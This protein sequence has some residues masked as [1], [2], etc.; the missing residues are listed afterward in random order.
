MPLNK[1]YVGVCNGSNGL[2]TFCLIGTA[3]FA[4]SAHLKHT[5]FASWHRLSATQSLISRLRRFTDARFWLAGPS[6]L[7]GG[8]LAQVQLFVELFSTEV[9]PAGFKILKAE[10]QEEVDAGKEALTHGL[11]VLIL[12]TLAVCCK[13]D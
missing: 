3:F 4:A 7:C 10:S 6:K 2:P 12:N 9:Q 5:A 8:S 13:T 11:K 1:H